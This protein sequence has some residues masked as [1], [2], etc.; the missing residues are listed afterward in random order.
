[1]AIILAA[2]PY[3]GAYKL[4]TT[5]NYMKKDAQTPSLAVINGY[6]N[7]NV[8]K[9]VNNLIANTDG[10]KI[11]PSISTTTLQDQRDSA[12]AK[13]NELGAQWREQINT[14]NNKYKTKFPSIL[15]DHLEQWKKGTLGSAEF[16]NLINTVFNTQI[17]H[18][19]AQL[20][21]EELIVREKFQKKLDASLLSATNIKTLE[22]LKKEARSPEQ[23]SQIQVRIDEL[24][25][26]E[27]RKKAIAE[28]EKKLAEAKTEEEKKKAK[29]DLDNLVNQGSAAV[30]TLS[31][32][33]GIPK[34]ALY[35]GIGVAV[36]IAGVLIYRG[37]RK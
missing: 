2:A 26:E 16:T 6:I 5:Y 4:Y 27:D 30:G 23:V 3:Y 17:N 32:A 15:K 20:M 13:A 8:N 37:I 28:A 24:Q 14:L 22:S 12:Q 1:M 18:V 36:V 31:S 21:N 33:T 10:Y 25:A 11:N 34:G 9:N 29:Q 19:S 7:E 35:I